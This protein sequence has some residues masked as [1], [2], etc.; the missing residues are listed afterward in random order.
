MKSLQLIREKGRTKRLHSQLQ[1]MPPPQE[2]KKEA[3]ETNVQE[4]EIEKRA[5]NEADIQDNTKV[6]IE[7]SPVQPAIPQTQIEEPPAINSLE[8][9]KEEQSIFQMDPYYTFNNKLEEDD[10]MLIL[11]I[12]RGKKTGN[13]AVI[14]RKKSNKFN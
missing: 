8:Q 1:A 2:E 3:K 10:I 14:E 12:L 6:I 4:K 7:I 9:I 13:T 5:K 11:D